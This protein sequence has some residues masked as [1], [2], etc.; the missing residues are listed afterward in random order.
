MR[1]GERRAA[2]AA[3]WAARLGAHWQPWGTLGDE[4][5]A[6]P[7]WLTAAQQRSARYH[8]WLRRVPGGWQLTPMGRALRDAIAARPHPNR[9]FEWATIT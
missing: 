6:Y 2:A 1:P 9:S 5:M 7:A 4:P 8:C 3:R